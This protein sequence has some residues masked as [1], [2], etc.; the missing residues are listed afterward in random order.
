VP[1]NARATV[2]ADIS[3]VSITK[4]P[5]QPSDVLGMPLALTTYTPRREA[6][7]NLFGAISAIRKVD[8]RYSLFLAMAGS[9]VC[10]TAGAADWSD[11]SVGYRYV[12]AQSE[13]GV[14]EKVAKTC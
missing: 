8:M 13:P 5:C 1:L 7:F 12:S 4:S 3:G 11:T 6:C 10:S 14:T 9:L 2:C